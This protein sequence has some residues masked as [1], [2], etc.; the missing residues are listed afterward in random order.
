MKKITTVV[1][2]MMIV[3][4]SASAQEYKKFRVGVGLGYAMPSGSGAGGGLAFTVEPGYRVN[5]KIIANLRLESALIV[6]GTVDETSASFD[7]AGIGSYTLNGQYYLMEGGF[8]PYVGAG[9][10]LFNIA[11]ASVD[12]GTAGGGV[13]ETA[14]TKIGFYPRLGFDAGHFTL[15][16]D[17][18]IVGNTKAVVSSSSGVPTQTEFKNSYIGIRI[19]GYFGGGRK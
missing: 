16:I 2:L 8:R 14:G 12:G 11:A 7:I 1:C 5:D 9:L 17:Y 13:S 4:L 19:G 3:A 6:R 15:N 10:G 18:N